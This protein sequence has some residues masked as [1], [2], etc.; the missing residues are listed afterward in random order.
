MCMAS[1]KPQKRGRLQCG[2]VAQTETNESVLQRFE[3]SY[4]HQLS[5]ELSAADP[6]SM[7][8]YKISNKLSL[9]LCADGKEM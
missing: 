7:H 3:S 6:S 5:F 2:H 9:V 1:D 4:K 8:D